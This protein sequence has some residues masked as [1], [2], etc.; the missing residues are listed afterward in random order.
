MYK[1]PLNSYRL[2]KV[3]LVKLQ[4]FHELFLRKSELSKYTAP[5]STSLLR[6]LGLNLSHARDK[7]AHCQVCYL[8]CPEHGHF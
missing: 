7:A 6:R 5:K 3:I 2:L 4:C 8:T 1:N